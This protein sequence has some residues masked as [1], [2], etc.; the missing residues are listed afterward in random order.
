MPQ[1]SQATETHGS[2]LT[3]ERRVDIYPDSPL[4]EYD[5]PTGKAYAARMKGDSSSDLVAILCASPL[6]PRADLVNA[7]RV[8]D[9][10]SLLRV[11]EGG[12]IHWPAHGAKYYALA[13]ERPLTPRY[14][15]SLNETHTPMGEDAVNHHFVVPIISALLELQRT[16]VVHGSIR[17]D[18]IFW[19][20]GSSTQ[21]QIGECLSAPPGIGQP[22]LFETIERGMCTPSGRGL[23]HHLDDC[24]AFGVALALVVMG[25]NPLTGVDDRAVLN[26]KIEQGSF[27]ALVGNKRLATGHIELLRGLLAD[28]PKQRW[29]AT[30]LEQWL[31]RKRM[32]PKSSDTG[33]RSSRHFSFAGKE[34]W[35]VRPLAMAMTAN[36]SEAAK[37]IESG[38]LEKW[39]TR[40]YGDEDRAESVNEALENLKESGKSSHYEDQLVT[41]ACIALDPAAPI[42]YRG[43]SVMPSGIATMLVEA[44]QGGTNAQILSE[45][46]AN[47]FVT[48]WVNQQK[49][50]KT[51]LVPLAQQIERIRSIIEKTSFGNGLE[52]AVYELN[53]TLPCLSPMLRGHYILSPRDI[54]PAL[55]SQSS[56][57]TRPSEPMDRHLAAFLIVH[58]KRSEALFSS[59]E[60]TQSPV[61]RGL[62]LL[63][64]FS[65]M[66]Y[67]YGP[68]QLPG[69]TSWLYPLVE[70]TISRFLSKPF[71]EKVR[72]Q[73]KQAVKDGN[74]SQ[75]MNL[76]DDPERVEHDEADF[77]RARQMYHDIQSEIASLEAELSHR[78]NISLKIGRP[79]AATI[80]S[81]L[82]IVFIAT[83]IFR[84]VWPRLGS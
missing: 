42:R 59:M 24:Y 79:V 70:T 37:E 44:L 55:E 33:R 71:Q 57:A 29:S 52:R 69:L 7:M 25:H 21:P 11:R 78:E 81:L 39:L 74:L 9:C 45:I 23:G 36:V 18:N 48:F 26:A 84:A 15:Q 68:E 62:A 43:V 3:L 27:N 65:E 41:R 61:R 56:S 46:I 2:T 75:L 80:A 13:Y 4:P 47:Q 60:P 66:Q 40:S 12:V 72:K 35:Q 31:S 30:E 64:L 6:P 1:A 83:T 14:W 34:Y 50:V 20:E 82:A 77:L 76:V 16:S 53:P 63:T 38:S 49:D 5:S 73:T 51:D 17:L 10:P 8:I 28:D 67:R 19:R 22:I 32:T 54:I 58:D